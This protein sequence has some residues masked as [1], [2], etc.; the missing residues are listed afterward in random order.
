M[1]HS[2]SIYHIYLHSNLIFFY[3]SIFIYSHETI[4]YNYATAND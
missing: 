1:L 3:L 2:Q 4:K